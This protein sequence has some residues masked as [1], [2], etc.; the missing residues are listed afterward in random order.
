MVI[1]K[2]FTLLALVTICLTAQASEEKLGESWHFDVN[3]LRDKKRT[4]EK[5]LQDGFAQVD[6]QSFKEDVKEKSL[7]LQGLF[8]ERKD[9]KATII[10]THGFCPGGKEKFAPLVKLVPEYCNLLFIELRGH[11]E[12]EG[13]SF[14]CRVKNYGKNEYK[15]IFGAIQFA[16]SK[17]NNKPIVIFGWC[18]G[19]F[20]SATTL[21]KMEQEAK[22]ANVKGLV[23]DSGF[24]SLMEISQV[25]Y[26]HIKNSYTPSLFVKWYNG[27]KK[28]ASQS[29]MCKLTYHCILKP[30]MWGIEFWTKP[31]IRKREPQTNLYD[32]IGQLH[33]PTLVIHA[34]DDQYAPWENLKKLVDAIPEKDLW[35]V[36]EGTSVH[37]T[38]HLKVKEEYKDKLHQ[39]IKKLIS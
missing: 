31:S 10:C 24:G 39:F 26:L 37:A 3:I 17:T 6:I 27:D 33:F 8:L 14:I 34:Q 16:Q 22:T 15:D 19:A 30:L 21:L 38:N 11:G 18:S 13:P 2:F 23:F 9:A 36:P 12:S 35:L 20:H 7:T 1:K 4:K 5:L 25:P 29:Y 28:R 32:K